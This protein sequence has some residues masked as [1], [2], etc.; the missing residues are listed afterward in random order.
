MKNP[1][2]WPVTAHIPKI[3]SLFL[4]LVIIAGIGAS[5]SVGYVVIIETGNPYPQGV[6]GKLGLVLAPLT[7]PG[8]IS[9]EIYFRSWE[10]NNGWIRVIALNACCYAFVYLVAKAIRFVAIS[11]GRVSDYS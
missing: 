5:V 11:R 9:N 6:L 2:F 4:E 10:T 8:I 7:M 1:M 3:A